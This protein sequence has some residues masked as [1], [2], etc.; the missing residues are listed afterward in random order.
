MEVDLIL[1]AVVVAAAA[2]AVEVVVDSGCNM[3]L[4]FWIV[5]HLLRCGMTSCLV[6]VLILCYW[7]YIVFVSQSRIGRCLS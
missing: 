6:F 5:I 2:A 3:V 7:L 1:I 4:E